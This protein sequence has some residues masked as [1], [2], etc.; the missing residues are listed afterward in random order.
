MTA[1]AEKHEIGCVIGKRLGLG[2]VMVR[3]TPWAFWAS[4][5]DMGYLAPF[6]GLT[7]TV[8]VHKVCPAKL[9]VARRLDPDNALCSFIGAVAPV[10]RL[11][12]FLF[13]HLASLRHLDRG[14][15]IAL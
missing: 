5:Q 14:C 1:R 4:W 3:S 15:G 2:F 9:A 7:C 12:C 13:S 6:H 11:R 8:V 10:G